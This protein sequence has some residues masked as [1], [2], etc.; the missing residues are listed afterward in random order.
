METTLHYYY[1]DTSDKDEANAYRMLCEDLRSMGLKCL[2]SITSDHYSFYKDKIKP[3]GGQTITLETKHLF[4]NQ[5]NTA[6]TVT[7]SNGLR[8]FDWSEPI[9]DNR[10]IHEGMWLKQ[11]SEM[12]EIRR[13]TLKCGYCGAQYQA[14]Q[15]YVF[16]EKCLDSEYLEEKE[17]Y[18]LRLLPIFKTWSKRAP[19]TKAEKA[20]L[21]P[22]YIERQ[23]T[24]TDSRNANKLRAQR[25]RI[26]RQ[27]QTA[28]EN[29]KDE[30]DG[31]LWLM[32]NG[33]SI[34]NVIYYNH[35]HRFCF[36]WRSPVSQAVKSKLLDVLCEF[37]FDYDIKGEKAA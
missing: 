14:A 32:D 6:P 3:L 5:W 31:L 23:T 2:L 27:Y 10:R 36:G 8:V 11:T 30:H 13:N 24:G 28:T 37:P 4:N 20:H 16:C 35:T 9:Y 12:N 15:G 18:L 29:A 19:L 25:Q 33:V 21:L 26:E 22:L 34:D 17:L 7:S 1:F